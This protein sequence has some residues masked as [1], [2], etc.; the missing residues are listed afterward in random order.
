MLSI[1]FYVLVGGILFSVLGVIATYTREEKP[2]IRDATRDWFAGVVITIALYF[3]NP[4]MMP[5]I[6]LIE[7]IPIPSPS[8]LIGGGGGGGSSHMVSDYPLQIGILR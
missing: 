7:S 1:L 3:I 2:T 4:S 8:K 5:P 6:D